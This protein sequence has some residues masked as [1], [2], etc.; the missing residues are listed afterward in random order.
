METSRKYF[1]ATIVVAQLFLKFQIS[2]L[3][4]SLAPLL[5]KEGWQPPRLTGWFVFLQSE[6]RNP[7]SQIDVPP[8]T[9]RLSGE[10]DTRLRRSI[11]GK[12]PLFR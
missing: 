1:T 6:F 7:K 3:K 11:C 8:P 9:R 5:T 4:L 12:A 2:N 10:L